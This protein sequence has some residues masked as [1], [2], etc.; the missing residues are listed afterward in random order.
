MHFPEPW[1]AFDIRPVVPFE[2]LPASDL[3]VRSSPQLHMQNSPDRAFW[4]E[5]S[6]MMRDFDPLLWLGCNIPSPG[7]GKK[8]TGKDD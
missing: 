8:E 2:H 6:P 1:P 5:A 3:W 4:E 7:C